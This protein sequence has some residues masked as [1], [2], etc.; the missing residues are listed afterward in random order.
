MCNASILV[1][2]I[3]DEHI[4]GML[5]ESQRLPWFQIQGHPRIACTEPASGPGDH[6][7]D[8]MYTLA[9]LPA[10]S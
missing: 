8:L 2:L 1:E 3:G 7:A 10:T 6:L 9:M 5:S 4:L